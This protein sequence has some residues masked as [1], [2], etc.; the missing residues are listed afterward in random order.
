MALPGNFG[1][2]VPEVRWLIGIKSGRWAQIEFLHGGHSLGGE[3]AW[4]RCAGG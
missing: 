4:W 1:R 3:R 2:F